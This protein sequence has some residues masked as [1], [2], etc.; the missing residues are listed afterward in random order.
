MVTNKSRER[1]ALGHEG[2]AAAGGFN[3]AAGFETET[4]TERQG[5]RGHMTIVRTERFLAPIML[6][7]VV[8]PR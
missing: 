6:A 8:L 5:E 2:T 4:E 7:E 1:I 3:A